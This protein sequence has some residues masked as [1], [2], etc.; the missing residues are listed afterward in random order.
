MWFHGG[1]QPAGIRVSVPPSVCATVVQRVKTHRAVLIKGLKERADA[2]RSERSICLE[3]LT[4]LS[5]LRV[6]QQGSSPARHRLHAARLTH[7][8]LLSSRSGSAHGGFA[9]E[10]TP[11]AGADRLS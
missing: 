4:G 6:S 8:I 5:E 1:C 9:K 11:G 2:S 3:K 10:A 7:H